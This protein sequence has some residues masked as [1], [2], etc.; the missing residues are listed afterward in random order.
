M[1][2]IKN[3]STK[4]IFFGMSISR[5][6]RFFHVIGREATERNGC[7]SEGASSISNYSIRSVTIEAICD[8]SGSNALNALAAFNILEK[9]LPFRKV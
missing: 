2:L 9:A 1:E 4:E 7:E 3:K 8:Y 5:R 6:T